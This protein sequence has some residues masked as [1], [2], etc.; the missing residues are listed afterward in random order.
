MRSRRSARAFTLI[1]I[2]VLIIII[3]VLSSVAVPRY[4]RFY[5]RTKFQQSVQAVVG[6]LAWARE[7]AIQTGADNL[8]RFDAQ[9]ETFLVTVETPRLEDDLPTALVGAS[10]AADLLEPRALTLGE[11]VVVRDF[12][13]YNL[14]PPSAAATADR[15]SMP[16]LRFREDGSCDGARFLLLSQDGYRAEIEVAPLT[17]RVVVHDEEG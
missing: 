4:A 9:T 3:A 10:D 14:R 7:A 12:A 2:I 13:V 17:G 1:E 16:Q 11:N 8:L 6:L 5:A 15:P